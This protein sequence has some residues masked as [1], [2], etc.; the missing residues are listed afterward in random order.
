METESIYFIDTKRVEKYNTELRKNS[1]VHNFVQIEFLKLEE[2]YKFHSRMFTMVHNPEKISLEN[3]W[4]WVFL[5]IEKIKKIVTD[6]NNKIL[7]AVLVVEVHMGS[8]DEKGPLKGYPHIH[9]VVYRR[10][11]GKLESFTEMH[12]QLRETSFGKTGEDIQI[13]GYAPKKR[14]TLE[15]SN[16][17]FFRYVI[18]NSKHEEPYNRMKQAYE[19]FKD[20]LGNIKDITTDVCFLIDNSGDKEIIDFFKELNKRNAIIHIPEEKLKVTEIKKVGITGNHRKNGTVNMTAADEKF[21]NCFVMVLEHMV[22]NGYKL[23]RDKVYVRK[24]GTRRTWEYWG[25]MSN[26]IGELYTEPNF[27]EF[28][29]LHKSEPGIIEIS[30]KDKQKI[31]PKIDINWFFIEFVDFYLHLPSYI[32]IKGEIPEELACGMSN[33]GITLEKLKE[34]MKPKIWLTVI[35][36]QVF[37]KSQITLEGFC[38]T[39]YSIFLPLIQKGKVLCLQGIANS[40]KT[41][42]IEPLKR[43]FPKEVQTEITTGQFVYSS[44]PG[45][46]LIGLDDVNHQVLDARNVKQ[47]FEGGRDMMMEAKFQNAKMDRFEGNIVI[48]ANMD[49]LPQTW[50]RAN[51]EEIGEFVLK[52]EYEVRL[53]IYQFETQIKN[54]EPGFLHRLEEEEI[55]KVIIYCGDKFAKNVL[56][57][58]TTMKI[59]ETYDECYGF[60]QNAEFIYKPSR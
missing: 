25:T 1:A 38:S 2:K 4:G 5:D 26:V 14:R 6:E 8:K 27:S 59:F 49:G 10:S 43:T 15:K 22:K 31:V 33:R 3:A 9:L 13:D 11:Q 56:K 39:Y 37:G 23:Y 12:S 45:K 44:L 50:Y 7:F 17:S 55:G 34:D 16:I 48:C 52:T 24:R 47:L 57:R 41:S 51:K 29:A 58:E 40:G 28:N 42:A 32:I 36:N 60:M 18:K 19:K 53:A 21:N 46:R 20:Q 30:L 54:P 35:Q